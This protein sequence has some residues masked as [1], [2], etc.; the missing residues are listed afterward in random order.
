MNDQQPINPS[1]LTDE[2]L[3][4]AILQLTIQQTALQ[5]TMPILV[6]E[7]IR[8]QQAQQTVSEPIILP[9]LRKINTPDTQTAS[10]TFP[11][12]YTQ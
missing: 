2:Q 12:Q 5:Q 11:T 7:F 6:S 9:K 3:T 8:R 1:T 4:A 10:Y